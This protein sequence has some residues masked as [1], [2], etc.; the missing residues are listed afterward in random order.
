MNTTAIINI[1]RQQL[2][3]DEDTYRALLV[4]VTGTASLRMMSER[5]KID[6]IEELKAKG[7]KVK[8]SGRT[9]PASVKP[10]IRLIHALWSNCARL[11]VIENGSREALRAFCKRFVAHGHDGVV[12]DP[13]LLSYAQATPIIEALKKME[14]RGKAARN[15]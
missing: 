14:A 5:Q 6:V 15:G 4:R 9:L 12:V 3:L 10:Y 1:A 11:G 2:G 13:D 7:F 8:K